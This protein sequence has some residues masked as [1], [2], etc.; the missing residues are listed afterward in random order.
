MQNVVPEVLPSYRVAWMF[1]HTLSS[2]NHI[3]RGRICAEFGPFLT[4]LAEQS[5]GFLLKF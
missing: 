3:L 5:E 2:L 1:T 4:G